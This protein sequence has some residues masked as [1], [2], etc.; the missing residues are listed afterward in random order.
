MIKIKNK[1]VVSI[2][3]LVAII[4]TAIIVNAKYM[5]DKEIT[6]ANLEI[7]RTKPLI[8]V[9]SVKQI[10]TDKKENLNDILLSVKVVE[11]NLKDVFFEK[12]HIKVKVGDKYVDVEKIE[13]SQIKNEKGEDI[14]QIDIIDI[15]GT[16]KVTIVFLEG[17]VV[18]NGGLTNEKFKVD[19]KIDINIKN[20]INDEN[21]INKSKVY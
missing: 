16:G 20:T 3:I 7:D 9:E 8:Q 11:Q 12:D 6:V 1:L 2:F 10:D 13:V 21:G 17:A 5:L 15:D 19:T 18:D 14:Y 4:S